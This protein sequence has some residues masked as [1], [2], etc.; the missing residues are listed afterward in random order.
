MYNNTCAP[1]NVTCC[2]LQML[3]SAILLFA[4]RKYWRSSQQANSKKGLAI[5]KGKHF[6][7]FRLFQRIIK[8]ALVWP[9][10]LKPLPFSR[11]VFRCEG[12]NF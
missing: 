9:E 5:S 4:K 2:T 10:I 11:K 3:K 8:G 12:K 7:I 1:I 6:S